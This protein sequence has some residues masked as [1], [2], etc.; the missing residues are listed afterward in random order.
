MDEEE[1]VS[2]D[3]PGY[4]G[5]L[6]YHAILKGYMIGVANASYAEDYGS[7]AK[8]LRDMYGFVAPY[9][10]SNDAQNCKKEIEKCESFIN[11]SKSCVMKSNE[12]TMLTV[13]RKRLRDATDNL[14]LKAKHLLLPVK[15]EGDDH[16]DEEDFLR[17]SDL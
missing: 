2:F 16:F 13:V 1:R 12:A 8:L 5:R 11:I 15:S 6:N 7:W 10:K 17:G 4:D 14:Y 3:K 9:M